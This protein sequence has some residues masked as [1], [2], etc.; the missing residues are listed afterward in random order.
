M[1]YS[2]IPKYTD[3]KIENKCEALLEYAITDDEYSEYIRWL[4]ESYQKFWWVMPDKLK[5]EIENDIVLHLQDCQDNYEIKEVT[6][7]YTTTMVEL[8]EKE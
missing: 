4:A 2:G 8:V 7:T 1:K 6:K 5:A 3:S